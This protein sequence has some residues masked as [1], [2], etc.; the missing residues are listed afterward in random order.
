MQT[1]KWDGSYIGEFKG[2]IIIAQY[3]YKNYKFFVLKIKL[4]NETIIPSRYVLV[5]NKFPNIVDEIKPIFNIQKT[6]SHSLKIDSQLYVIYKSKYK[7]EN[8]DTYKFFIDKSLNRFDKKDPIRMRHS[9]EIKKIIV[10]RELLALR[11]NIE[12]SILLNIKTGLL[13][14]INE[15]E[16]NANNDSCSRSI[17]TRGVALEWFI[18]NDIPFFVKCMTGNLSISDA[19]CEDIN[20]TTSRLKNKLEEIIER[21]D[22]DY[23]WFSSYVVNRCAN[24]LNQ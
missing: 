13:T 17:I 6:G 18:E 9:I 12:P 20:I 11:F 8:K 5:K 24:Y 2:D 4:V 23:I 19:D 3:T 1:L 22:K 21:V 15:I 7:I 14:S 16:T 10:F